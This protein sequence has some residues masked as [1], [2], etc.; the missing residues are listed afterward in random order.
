MLVSFAFFA[1]L[2]LL[3]FS[4]SSTGCDLC[5]DFQ[6]SLDAEDQSTVFGKALAGTY[7]NMKELKVTSF[8]QCLDA[9]VQDNCSC[10]S[11]NFKFKV[12]AGEKHI[13]ELNAETK[14]NSEMN[15]VDR[16][17]FSY[18]ELVEIKRVSASYTSFN[19]LE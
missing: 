7:V 18:H 3:C 5:S 10:M 16:T 1:V 15:L 2:Q 9:C 8:L 6:A 13:C 4:S 17:D 12:E 11:I 19:V 14:A